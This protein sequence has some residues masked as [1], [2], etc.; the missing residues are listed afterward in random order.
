MGEGDVSREKNRGG[1]CEETT[2]PG[3]KRGIN[4]QNAMGGR[5]NP[6]GRNFR[7]IQRGENEKLKT[8]TR[9]RDANKK[10]AC[11]GNFGKGGQRFNQKTSNG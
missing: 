2:S 10:Q 5:G 8:L 7:R 1:G 4:E 9:K 3:K 11:F 6:Y